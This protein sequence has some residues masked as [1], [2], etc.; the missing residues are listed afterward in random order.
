MTRCGWRIGGV[1]T[2][3]APD[4]RS[5]ALCRAVWSVVILVLFARSALAADQKLAGEDRSVPQLLP[6]T[7]V[8]YAEIPQPKAVLD[9]ALDHA[10][11]RWLEAR[12]EF[13]A[14]TATPQFN[15]FRNAVGLFEAQVKQNWREALE[16]LLQGGVYVAVDGKSEGVALL[17]KSGDRAKLASLRDFA[18]QFVAAQRLAQGGEAAIRDV[19]YRGVAAHAAGELRFGVLGSWFVLTNKSELGKEIVDRLLGDERE[20]LAANERFKTALSQAGERSAWAFFDVATLRSSGKA[21]QFYRE[22]AN[23][24]GEEFFIGGLLATMNKTAYATAKL[25]L[26]PDELRFALAAPTDP[27]WTAGPREFYFGPAGQGAAP[28]PLQPK[29]RLFTWT[30]YR[31]LAAMWRAAPDL[32]NDDIVTKMDQAEAQLTT[33]FAGREFTKD[34]LGAIAPQSQIV[35]ARQTFAPGGPHEPS[36]KLPAFALVTRL[37]D[38]D[39][40]GKQ[41][42][43]IFQSFVGFGNIIGGQQG[44]PPLEIR[45]EQRGA[46]KLVTTAYTLEDKGLSTSPGRINYNF[47]PS[48]ALLG[49]H[50]VLSS[51]SDFAKELCDLLDSTSTGQTSPSAAGAGPIGQTNSAVAFDFATLTKLLEDNR[52]HLVAQNI[53]QKGHDQQAAELE[54]GT[55]LELAGMLRDAELRLATQDAQL[56]FEAVVRLKEKR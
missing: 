9:V 55:L 21:P 16:T 19:E 30:I 44:Q 41:M 45:S 35:A 49:E 1:A 3:G 50:M 7:T 53:L 18:L 15:Q 40:L 48:L 4:R 54:I 42:T 13:I 34:V 47:S 25:S 32:F 33:L 29:Q 8:I 24:P 39:Q 5:A 51:T 10:I 23:D 52:Q 38:A 20:S 56:K 17:V 37:R 36:I 46:A 12:P 2:N 11:C 43:I 28:L 22:K 14:A 27:A 6:A 26:A 31:D